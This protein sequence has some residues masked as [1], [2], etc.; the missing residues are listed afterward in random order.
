MSYIHG[1]TIIKIAV[2]DAGILL[3]EALCQVIN[4]WDNCKVI[5]QADNGKDFLELLDPN[6]LPDL[7]L[8]DLEMPEMNGFDTIKAAKKNYPE[9]KFMLVSRHQNEEIIIH[10]IH[11][12]ANGYFNKSGHP[13][14]L[15]KAFNEMMRT[16]YFFADHAAAR[17]MK[18]SMES[19]RF[20]LKKD[21]TDEEFVFL[22]HI[23]TQKTYPKIARDMGISLRH[24]EYIRKKMFD[25]FDVQNRIGL[26]TLVIKK[27]LIA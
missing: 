22:K 12:G 4:T 2:A 18:Q 27:G 20:A 9:I 6:N 13:T 11:V 21:L 7:V 23:I 16:G 15:K 1:K 10:L 26:A 14:E 24:A 5:W 19:D 3:R 25:H 17:L 8:M